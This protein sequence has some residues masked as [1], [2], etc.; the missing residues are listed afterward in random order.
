MARGLARGRGRGRGRG[1]YM[2]DVGVGVS[3]IRA[4]KKVNQNLSPVF[5]IQFGKNVFKP[6][7]RT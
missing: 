6:P 3:V 1:T 7:P 5:L 4:D 2:D